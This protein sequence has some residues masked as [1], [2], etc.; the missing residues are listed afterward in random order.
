[1]SSMIAFGTTPSRSPAVEPR[2]GGRKQDLEGIDALDVRRHGGTYLDLQ[3]HADISDCPESYDA[4]VPAL[5]ARGLNHRWHIWSLD[6]D[7]VPVVIQNGDFA[8]TLPE[9]LAEMHAIIDSI[10]LL[11]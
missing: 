3:V 2:L 6:V 10:Q 7:G 11:H 1:M 9:D 4:W 8:G 5:Y